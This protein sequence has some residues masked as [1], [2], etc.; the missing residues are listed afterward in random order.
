MARIYS[1]INNKGG[2]GKTT[3]AL[4]FGAALAEKGFRV[5]LLDFDSQCNLSS[6][7]GAQ[8]PG[9]HLGHVL[10][11][12]KDM[13]QA[14]VP[15]EKLSLVPSTKKLLDFE[16]LL[17]S[18]PGREY[19]VQEALQAIEPDYDFILMD[20]PPS[21]GT[22]SVNSLVAADYYIVP[23]QTENFAFLGLD[24]LL[25]AAEK[26]RQRMNSSL[27]LAGILL[28]QFADRTKFGRAV[29]RSI[30]QSPH[31]QGKLFETY[32][33]QDIALMESAA[34]QQSIFDYA[35]K[36]RGAEDYRKFTNEIIARYGPQE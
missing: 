28:T 33:R 36:S 29:V 23:M 3:T 16:L 22:L 14:I 31:L 10:L 19:V 8:H 26:V 15:L 4:N 34:F 24:T 25:M 11:R 21:L 2:T 20:C 1:V 9:A 27:E 30:E 35:P 12:K 17:N 32:I 5:L 18:E 6:A 13:G 7:L